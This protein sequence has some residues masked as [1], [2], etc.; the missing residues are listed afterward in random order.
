M[1]QLP[2]L[3]RNPFQPDQELPTSHTVF[4]GD[5]LAHCQFGRGGVT[6]LAYC[7]DRF[8]AVA[9][10]KANV[11]QFTKSRYIEAARRHGS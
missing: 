1:A 6:A 7:D 11:M 2:D 10:L 9:G 5:A 4:D 8:T 3:S